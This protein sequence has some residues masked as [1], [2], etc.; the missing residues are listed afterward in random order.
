M[1]DPAKPVNPPPQARGSV[2]FDCVGF[3]YPMRSELQALSEVS[4]SVEPEETVALV[5]PSGSGKS[6][7]FQLLL[8]FFDP[9]EGRIL[10]DGIDIRDMERASFRRRIALVPQEPA[11]FADTARE[12]IRFGE[13]GAG[14]AEVVEAA[15]AGGAHE[16]LSELPQ[17]YDTYVG[18]RGIMLSGGQKQRIAIS[19]AI[20]RSAPILLFDE[21]T[22]S[23]DAE[24]ER[25]VQQAVRKIAQG[26][27]TIM[28]AHR[29]ATVK[30]ADRILV[31][32]KGRIVAEGS[33][34]SLVR[35]DGLYARLAKLQF[36][37]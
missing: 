4:F 14:D 26:R 25:A 27:T 22:S 9:E 3:R 15:M 32:D 28:I 13:A 18:E 1:H 2:K 36:S 34:D 23:L 29:L 30:N 6:T 7:V 24:S 8:R 10:I 11:I 20:L 17:G 5:G 31:L 35:E 21:A 33:H 19:R 12:N 16:F 37:L